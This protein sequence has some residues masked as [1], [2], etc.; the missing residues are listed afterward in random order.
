MGIY[1]HRW[2]APESLVDG[3]FTRHSDVWS[4]GVLLWEV[5]T[6]GQ[7][8][9]QARSNVEVLQYVRSGGRLNRPTNCPPQL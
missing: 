4:F 1:V 2:M 8:P 5:M 9:Y 3:V 7:Q 6:L